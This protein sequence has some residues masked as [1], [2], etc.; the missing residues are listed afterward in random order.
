MLA[1]WF[2]GPAAASNA[3]RRRRDLAESLWRRQRA[4]RCNPAQCVLPLAHTTWRARQ[5]ASATDASAIVYRR[6]MRCCCFLVVLHW[7][8]TGTALALHRQ[9]SDTTLLLALHKYSSDALT[10]DDPSSRLRAALGDPSIDPPIPPELTPLVL[11]ERGPAPRASR[12]GR[13]AT[14]S[15]PPRGRRAMATALAR[16]SLRP[17]SYA[18]N[19][20]RLPEPIS[21][22]LLANSLRLV[23]NP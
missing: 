22:T 2:N 12:G 16:R 23:A 6:R 10:S 8:D 17:S 13:Q 11:P 9:Y 1:T 5:R 19:G 14:A 20:G 3:R 15:W 18:A 21:P 7:Y 4:A